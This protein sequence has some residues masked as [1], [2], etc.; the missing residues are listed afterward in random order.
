VLVNARLHLPIARSRWAET[1][2]RARSLLASLS[3]SLLLRGMNRARS[4]R[5]AAGLTLP[6]GSMVARQ[7]R[8]TRVCAGIFID[9]TS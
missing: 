8:R 7:S 9:S 5:C 6:V 1:V 2:A 4:R 3:S